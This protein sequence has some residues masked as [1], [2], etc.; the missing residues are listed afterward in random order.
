MLN[1]RYN[2]LF[3]KICVLAFLSPHHQ[4]Q[5]RPF[6]SLF[7]L[8]KHKMQKVCYFEATVVAQHGSTVEMNPAPFVKMKSLFFLLAYS[9]LIQRFKL[10]VIIN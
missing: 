2:L 8:Q 7:Y 10:Q 1:N 5:I 6:L 4:T 9:L 3:V